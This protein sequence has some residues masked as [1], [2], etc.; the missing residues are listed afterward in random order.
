MACVGCE[1]TLEQSLQVFK[2][3]TTTYAF[4]KSHRVFD[5][6][7]TCPNCAQP[8]TLNKNRLVWRCQRSTINNGIRTSCKFEQS[9][10][11]TT[12]LKGSHIPIHTI[13]KL[14]AYFLLLPQPHQR[15]LHTELGISETTIVKWSHQIRQAEL[16]WCQKHTPQT[17]G[18][19]GTVVEVDEAKFGHRKYNRGRVVNEQWIFGGFQRGS[20]SVFLEVVPNRTTETLME[21]IHRRI[22]PGTT[23]HTDGWR[24]YNSIAHEGN[25]T[26][27]TVDQSQNTKLINC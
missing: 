9:Y 8:T 12:W 1:L 11:T 24:A 27:L 13:G 16:D 3:T 2:N 4:F 10:K 14:I 7:V 25:N 18:G 22:R 21:I 15:L 23:I 5:I 6:P 20:K 19:P 17:L 26:S